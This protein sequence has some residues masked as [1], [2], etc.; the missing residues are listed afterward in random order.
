MCDRLSNTHGYI[1]YDCFEELVSKGPTADVEDFMC[2]KKLN[3]NE[4]SARA[5]FVIEFPMG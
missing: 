3:I 5:R 2:S 1:C 4:E